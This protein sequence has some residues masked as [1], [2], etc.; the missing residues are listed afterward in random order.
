MGS[1]LGC[2]VNLATWVLQVWLLGTRLWPS[3]LC[4][5]LCNFHDSGNTALLRN[6]LA[7][8][9]TLFDRIGRHEP[10]ATIAGFALS[11]GTAQAI[12][13]RSGNATSSCLRSPYR[14]HARP[15]W[16]GLHRTGR[17]SRCALARCRDY[18]HTTNP[19]RQRAPLPR[20]QVESVVDGAWNL[21]GFW[22]GGPAGEARR[23]GSGSRPRTG[24]P[25]PPRCRP[26]RESACARRRDGFRRSRATRR[27]TGL[28]RRRVDRRRPRS[29]A[30]PSAGS[31]A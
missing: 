9:A 11:P 23:P 1:F 27:R 31:S 2:G 7:I 12:S 28:S 14:N 8:L 21:L 6:P 26:C 19:C 3:A 29:C 15:R 10:A 25:R 17:Y 4:Q 16:L 30:R 5:P 20:P 24:W 22:A 18:H 13:P